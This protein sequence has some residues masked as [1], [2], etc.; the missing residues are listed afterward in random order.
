MPFGGGFDERFWEMTSN[1]V[2]RGGEPRSLGLE[3]LGEKG[4]VKFVSPKRGGGKGYIY[5]NGGKK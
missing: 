4:E 2:K 1:Y 5:I 3:L